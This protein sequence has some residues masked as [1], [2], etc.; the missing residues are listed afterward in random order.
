MSRGI[1]TASF[2]T[3]RPKFK[4]SRINPIEFVQR[5]RFIRRHKGNSNVG[6]TRSL[7]HSY[8]FFTLYTFH[9]FW[10]FPLS[11]IFVS[12]YKKA[13]SWAKHQYKYTLKYTH[14]CFFCFECEDVQ[15]IKL[16][17]HRHMNMIKLLENICFKIVTS[18]SLISFEIFP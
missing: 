3:K 14:F 13:Y 6:T 8:F 12:L 9:F 16:N 5:Q 15:W 7:S 10:R 17:E 2:I 18:I 11:R 4:W 1:P